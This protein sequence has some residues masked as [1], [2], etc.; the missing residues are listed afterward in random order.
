MQWCQKFHAASKH[1]AVV[2]S[3]KPHKAAFVRHYMQHFYTFYD[4]IYI[5]PQHLSMGGFRHSATLI[6]LD[7]RRRRVLLLGPS[8]RCEG[9]VNKAYSCDQVGYSTITGQKSATSSSSSSSPIN[10]DVPLRT[11]Q[12]NAQLNMLSYIS[13]CSKVLMVECV[14]TLRHRGAEREGRA[15]WC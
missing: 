8:W 5:S 2:Q 12:G 15:C 3:Q 11:V 6:S 7:H 1:G 10:R 9:L 4:I 13:M 14:C